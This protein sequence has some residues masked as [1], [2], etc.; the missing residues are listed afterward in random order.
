LVDQR[1]KGRK[2]PI[3]VSDSVWHSVGVLREI[4]MKHD[5]KHDKKS[6]KRK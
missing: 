1:L 2:L 5:K 3:R 6:A 4:K